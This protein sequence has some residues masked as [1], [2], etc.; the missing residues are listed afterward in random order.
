LEHI[1][2]MQELCVSVHIS[3]LDG[4][5]YIFYCTVLMCLPLT[6]SLHCVCRYS[7]VLTVGCTL[8]WCCIHHASCYA[9]ILMYQKLAYTI[10]KLI[11]F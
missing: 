8:L 6:I 11:T 7:Q 4:V 9:S 1:K 10:C 5:F 3:M 2:M